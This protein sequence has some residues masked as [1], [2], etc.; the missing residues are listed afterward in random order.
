MQAEHV[1]ADPTCDERLLMVVYVTVNQ[2]P[3]FI[4]RG[5][6]IQTVPTRIIYAV[7]HS[8]DTYD[9]HIRCRGFIP[10]DV[11]LNDSIVIA[12]ICKRTGIS[13]KFIVAE[14]TQVIR[15][16]GG[17]RDVLSGRRRRR[18][19]RGSRRRCRRCRSL[20]SHRQREV[21]AFVRIVS[22]RFDGIVARRKFLR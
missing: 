11:V 9:C 20:H 15:V 21:A 18:H 12:A 10:D 8:G 2:L 13:V 19:W 6:V 7:V 14:M 3:E 17:F 22:S 1:I 4:Q 5:R 16:A